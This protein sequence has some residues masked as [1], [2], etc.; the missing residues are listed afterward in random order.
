MA[1]NHFLEE[2]Y[3]NDVL[4]LVAKISS[5]DYYVVMAQAWLLSMAYVKFSD[6]TISFLKK[7]KISTDVYAKTLQKIL[8]SRQISLAQREDV[9]QL[10][11]LL[12]T[13]ATE[14]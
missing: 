12:K 1:L 4:D 8:E 11:Y 7:G 6:K 3:L 14:H 2:T 5:A 13:N 10:R 9:K